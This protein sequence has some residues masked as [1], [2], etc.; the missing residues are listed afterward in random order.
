MNAANQDLLWMPRSAVVAAISAMDAYIHAVLEE[1]IPLALA[2]A[3]IPDA[4][5]NAMADLLPIK[6]GNNFKSAYPVLSSPNTPT[7]LATRLRD[8]SLQFLSYQAPEKIIA[9]YSLIG[10]AG[11]FE[12]VAALWPGP[13][14][15]ADEIKRRLAS[16]VKRRNQIAHEG[17]YESG[18]TVRQMQ[19]KYANDCTEFITNLTLRLDRVIYGDRAALA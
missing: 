14:T 18:G 10:S 2:A 3:D 19:P 16:Y 8:Q 7:V 6:S 4:L 1:R 13:G 17:D 5:A 11:I 12:E 9:A 15:T